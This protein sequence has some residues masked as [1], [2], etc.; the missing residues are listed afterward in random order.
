M[1][2][3][4]HSEKPAMM[5]HS[6][7]AER[8]KDA[9]L[10]VL[11]RV[12]PRSGVLLEVASGSGQHAAW[13]APKLAPLRWQPSDIATD[14]LSSIEAWCQAHGADHVLPPR[15]LDVTSSDWSLSADPETVAVLAINMVH[16]A[17]WSATQGLLAGS[18]NV[19]PDHGQLVLYGPFMRGGCHT[20]PSNAAFDES[21][22]ARDPSWG[23][24][25]LDAVASLAESHGLQVQEVVE[26]PANNLMVMFSP[27]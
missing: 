20:A 22:R 11:Q 1:P 17:P 10:A 15:Y 23:V 9:I 5:R 12:L 25:D 13:C 18:A 6:P 4:S 16:I 24:R 8:N 14:N 26:M 2:S 3:D 19:L 7:A 27:V 21:L